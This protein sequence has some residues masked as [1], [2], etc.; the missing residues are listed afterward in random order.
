MLK[1]CLEFKNQF[2]FY[3]WSYTLLNLHTYSIY[4]LFTNFARNHTKFLK[5]V[6][7]PLFFLTGSSLA[8]F[9]FVFLNSLD[10]S[11]M[12]SLLCHVVSFPSFLLSMLILSLL[13]PWTTCFSLQI[14]VSCPRLPSLQKLHFTCLSM[15][16][17]CCSFAMSAHVSCNN[18]G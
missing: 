15:L 10:A 12:L 18:Q 3:I 8:S 11:F 17:I 6:L 4:L 9:S 16:W 5:K 2:H 7:V 1:K 13:L 14:F